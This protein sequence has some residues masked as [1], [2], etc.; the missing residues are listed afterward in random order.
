[1]VRRQKATEAA[2]RLSR[3]GFFEGFT[4]DE[5]AR[6]ATLVD[7]VEAEPGAVLTDQGRPG[8]ECY[9]IESGQ[10]NVYFGGEHI[11]T[12]GP[13]SMVGE[14]ALLEHRP[15]IATVVAETRM[16]LLGLDTRS[17][18]ALLDEMPKA[19]QRVMSLLNARLQE[20]A[21]RAEGEPG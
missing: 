15:R 4:A 20:N 12:L 2:E 5:L 11:A 6:V 16:R 21:Q 10:A 19:S 8:T 13:G 14:M 17:F 9:V 1:M 7:D 18:R 3:I